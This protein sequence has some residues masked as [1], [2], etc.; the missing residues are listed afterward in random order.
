MFACPL[1]FDLVLTEVTKVVCPNGHRLAVFKARACSICTN[2]K[3]EP[4]GRISCP[5]GHIES[6]DMEHLLDMMDPKIFLTLCQA[7][8]INL[9]APLCVSNSFSWHGSLA[10]K[11]FAHLQTTS[12]LLSIQLFINYG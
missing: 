4:V 7:Q 6:H 11:I 9:K 3:F 2:D 12:H 5:S 1:F 10:L 8:S